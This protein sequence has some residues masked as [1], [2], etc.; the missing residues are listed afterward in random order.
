MST[1][2]AVR[3]PQALTVL[4]NDQL[5]FIA[6]TEFVPKGLRNNLPAILA[7]VATG[8]AIG[9]DDMTAIRSI[10]IIDGKPTFAAELMV[11]LVRRRG[12]SITGEV[13]ADH[14]TVTG[15]R[16]D[17]GDSMTSTFTLEMAKRAGLASKQNWKNYPE[18]M[19]WARAVSQLCRMLF[20]D[21]FAGGTYTAEELGDEDSSDGRAVSDSEASAERGSDDQAPGMGARTP[22]PTLPADEWDGTFPPDA[23]AEIPP[24]KVITRKQVERLVAVANSHSVSDARLRVIVKEHAGVESTKEIPA[25][26]YDALVA[27]VELEAPEESGFAARA[28][29]AQATREAAEAQA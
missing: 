6:G 20:A 26:V 27:A 12:H 13:T 4:S 17:N 28:A 25:V 14:A 15:T 1:D 2:V 22:E 29:E 11:M 8:R 24:V 16:A 18:S 19:C 7:C 3:E 9:I 5:K 23:D 10:H 21:C